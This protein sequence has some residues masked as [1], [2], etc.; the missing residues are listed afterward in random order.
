MNQR[1][2]RKI[3]AGFIIALLAVLITAII[4]FRNADELK[5]TSDLVTHTV[6][7]LEQLEALASRMQEEES[8]ARGFGLTGNPAFQEPLKTARLY[9]SQ[10][11]RRLHELAVDNPSQEKRLDSLEIVVSTAMGAL[12][13][14]GEYRAVPGEDPRKFVV[15]A[16]EEERAPAAEARALIARIG[17]E[18]RTLL[19]QRQAG[20]RAAV[21]GASGVVALGFWLCTAVVLLVGVLI[22]TGITDRLRALSAGA[23]RIGGGDYDHRI[24][25]RGRDEVAEAAS[26]FNEMAR[27]ISDR[28]RVLA[29]ETWLKTTLSAFSTS[30]QGQRDLRSICQTTL[31]GLARHTQIQYGVFYLRQAAPGAPALALMA[32]YAC[33]QAKPSVRAGEGLAGQCL[34]SKLRVFLPEAPAGYLKISSALGESNV[35]SV[36]VLP[37]LFDGEVMAVVE[38]ARFQP[39]T[40]IQLAFLDQ[41]AAN[42]GVVLNSARSAARTEELL[43]EAKALTESLRVQQVAL[44]EKNQELNTQAE[45][46]R[47]S[48][49]MLREQ[50]EELRQ[51]NAELEQANQ[52]LHKTGEEMEEKA[53]LL[54]RQK[55]A[56]EETNRELEVARAALEEKARQLARTSQYKS[57]FLANMSHELRT[58]LNSLL[59]LS[60]ILAENAAGNLTAKQVQYAQTIH[61][62]GNDLLSLINEI[63]DLSK[64]E[65]GNAQ[66]NLDETSL[67]ELAR[68]AEANFRHVAEGKGL[69]FRVLIDES[70]PA[71]ITTDLRRLHQIVANLLSNAFKF[72]QNGS[73]ELRIAAAQNGWR[74]DCADLN[75]AGQVVSFT[76]ADTGIGISE[77]KHELI[78]E[79]FRQAEAGT[80]RK[81]G[82][83]G[84][85]LAICRELARLLGGCLTVSSVPGEGSRFTLYL[86]DSLSTERARVLRQSRPDWAQVQYSPPPDAPAPVAASQS[87][88]LDG[89]ELSYQDDRGDLKAGD[90]VLL[91]IEDDPRFAQVLVEIA[92]KKGFKAVAVDTAAD[93]VALAFQLKPSAITL[94][95]QLPD[96]DGWVVLDRLKH[97]PGTRHIP[98]HVISVCDQRGRGLRLGA[99]SY[100][101]K[102]VT[103]EALEA[104][105]GQTIEFINRPAKSI[106]VVED[107]TTQRRSII[108]LIGD[109]DVTTAEAGNAAEALAALGGQAF[110]CVVVD[111]GLPDMAGA[112]LIREIH[113]RHGMASPPVVIYTG[114]SITREEESDLRALSDSVIVKDAGSPERLLDETALFLHRAQATLP[115]FKRRM[116]DRARKNDAVLSGRKVLVVDDDIRNIFAITSALENCQMRVL[117]AESG[118]SALETLQKEPDIEAV[119]LDVMMP[120]MDG[121]E[122]ARRIRQIGRLKRLPVIFLTAKTMA[123]DREKCLE[124]GGSDYITKPADMD[125]LR[126]L[127]RVR[128]CQDRRE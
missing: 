32:S 27:Q 4:S 125:Q 118:R 97:D 36:V 107:D 116:L 88:N 122:T 37:V 92:R 81:Y 102:P 100:L 22:S 46:L 66:I 1:I 110:D 35:G 124:A 79:A 31:D 56:L 63:L 90:L 54:A 89:R 18:E 119:L 69:E 75:R 78:F 15:S 19:G 23:A 57:E 21:E 85:G 80:E 98:V 41:F 62:S 8:A 50:Q 48:G 91:I 74:P 61:S 5:S 105:L 104:V 40:P 55:A 73:V 128:L 29:G 109:A 115:E 112:Q 86:P 52:E 42:L 34:A 49:R 45:Q 76:V 71:A 77:D 24:A 20:A 70:A 96:G 83:T 121:F 51:T 44:N 2:G 6:Q 123:G 72:T 47:E 33:D 59:I 95:L 99:V 16:M 106:L 82:G 3:A 14:V 108:E 114:K 68:T 93:G 113:R 13:R 58:P 103:K 53:G 7:V 127:L 25:I 43:A 30:F 117:H 111:L 26:M 17:I 101:E 67:E 126:S 64:I 12:Q 87:A 28:Q 9:A 39:F 65:S 10:K 11:I 60:K 84:L 38:V 94:D 120:E